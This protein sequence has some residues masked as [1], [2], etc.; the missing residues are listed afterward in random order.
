MTNYDKFKKGTL[1]ILLLKLLSQKDL[2]GYE[3]IQLVKKLS[4]SIIT[5]SAGNMYTMLNKLEEKGLISSYKVNVNKRIGRIYYHLTSKGHSELNDM[6][7][8]YNR[9]INATFNILNYTFEADSK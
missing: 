4:N 7:D 2:Y 8:D 3:I 9:L 5:I 6:L 1:E